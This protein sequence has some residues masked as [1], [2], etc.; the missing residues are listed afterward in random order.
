LLLVVLSLGLLGVGG[1]LS[2]PS[3][4]GSYYI[5]KTETPIHMYGEL[6]PDAQQIVTNGSD[7]GNVSI[8]GVPSEF[9]TEGWNFVQNGDENTCVYVWN[10]ATATVQNCRGIAFEFGNLSDRGQW[11]VSLA[12]NST[13]NRVDI[14][15]KSPREFTAGGTDYGGFVPPKPAGWSY[16]GYYYVFENG[17]VYELSVEEMSWFPGFFARTVYYIG[18]LAALVIGGVSYYR[19]SVGPTVPFLV[20]AP[21]FI[22]YPLAR[23]ILSDTGRYQW[24]RW[25]DQ[26][27]FVTIGVGLFIVTSLGVYSY[28]IYKR[29]QADTHQERAG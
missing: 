24:V 10:T 23:G 3:A 4:D 6:S 29:F 19:R 18:G 15:Q 5:E 25:L 2:L 13:D 8:D 16:D 7:G 1:A 14:H 12:L 9:R 26:Q 22:A 17:T 27:S 21:V 20:S 11:A 28:H